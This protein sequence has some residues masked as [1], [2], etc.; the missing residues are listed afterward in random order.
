MM[1][2][3]VLR[4]IALAL[5]HH[6]SA[7]RSTAALFGFIVGAGLGAIVIKRR[8]PSLPVGWLL[9]GETALLAAFTILISSLGTHGP[10]SM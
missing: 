7:V 9:T 8:E 1:A 5:G 2:N 10:W 3:L 4:L 6:R